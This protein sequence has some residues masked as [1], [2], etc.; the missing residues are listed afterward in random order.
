MNTHPK[1]PNNRLRIL[2]RALGLTQGELGYLLGY[3]GHSQAARLEDGAK[4]PLFQEALIT[5][6]VLGASAG[7]IFPEAKQTARRKVLRRLHA[8]QRK[9]TRTRS[10][11]PRLSYKAAQLERVTA[12]IRSREASELNEQSRWHTNR[13]IFDWV[14]HYL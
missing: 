2:R 12:A 13:K 9:L 6:L 8:L 3:S 1:P 10:T 4:A 14:E 5:E 11:N 7:D